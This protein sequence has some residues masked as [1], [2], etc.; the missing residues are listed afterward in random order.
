[1]T[2]QELR[3][4]KVGDRVRWNDLAGHVNG[5]VIEKSHGVATIVWDD[6]VAKFRIG[7]RSDFD[8]QKGKKLSLLPKVSS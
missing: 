4:L 3:D 8:R 6:G 2:K 1:M 5:T 7:W